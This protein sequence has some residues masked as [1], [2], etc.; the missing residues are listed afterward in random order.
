MIILKGLH[1]IPEGYFVLINLFF[2][3]IRSPMKCLCYYTIQVPYSNM[4]DSM[5]HHCYSIADSRAGIYIRGAVNVIAI[6]EERQLD[7]AHSE[8][9]RFVFV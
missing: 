1:T 8:Q 7:A 6:A 4:L 9:A 3:L 2:S 5:M